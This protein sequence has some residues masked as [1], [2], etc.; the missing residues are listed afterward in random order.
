MVLDDVVAMC[1]TTNY[2]CT[3]NDA[4]GR[5]HSELPKK[6]EKKN[7]DEVQ[8]DGSGEVREFIISQVRRSQAAERGTGVHS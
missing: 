2:L 4:V 1:C 7:D 5:T 3:T 6:R 8:M